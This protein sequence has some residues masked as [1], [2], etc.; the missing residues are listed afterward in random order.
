MSERRGQETGLDILEEIERHQRFDG[1]AVAAR[2]PVP[3]EVAQRLE[4]AD[5]GILQPLL[6]TAT[7]SFLLFPVEQCRQP[8]LGRHFAPVGEQAMQ[9]QRAGAVAQ[10]VWI[11]HR[12]G[13]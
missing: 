11:T 5:M 9:M 2:R 12:P 6:Q 4:A 3:V 8:G 1:G 7:G 13:P 10:D